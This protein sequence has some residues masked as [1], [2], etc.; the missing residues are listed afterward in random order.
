M[1]RISADECDERLR[2]FE[3]EWFRIEGPDGCAL[4]AE[5]PEFERFRAGSP[6]P[7]SEIDWWKDWLDQTAGITQQGK[8]I[9]R[10][11]I[12]PDEG[13]TEYQRWLIWA[14]PWYARAGMNIR[15]MTRSRA[16]SLGLPPGV[17]WSLLDSRCVIVHEFNK[18]GEVTG[19]DLLTDAGTVAEYVR[20]RDIAVQNATLADPGRVALTEG[21]AHD[22]ARQPRGTALAAA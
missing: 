21:T 12:T 14:G 2:T 10:I 3:R 5:L 22:T 9:I 16:L 18:V 15:Y 17:D 1:A 13:P 20:W 6:R 4:G 19:W 8:A 11:R 7:P